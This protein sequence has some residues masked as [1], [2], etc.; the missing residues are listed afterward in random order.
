MLFREMI[1]VYFGTIR[2]TQIHCLGRM[3]GFY[4][5]K[6]GGT[7]SKRLRFKPRDELRILRIK[8]R[9]LDSV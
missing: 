7:Y 2:N 8:A 5:V 4:C 1:V 6:T 3:Q 9:H